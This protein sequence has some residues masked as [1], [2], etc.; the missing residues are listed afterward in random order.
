MNYKKYL[1]W[2]ITTGKGNMPDIHLTKCHVIP[3]EATD[4]FSMNPA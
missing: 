4:K 3:G 1:M 2:R